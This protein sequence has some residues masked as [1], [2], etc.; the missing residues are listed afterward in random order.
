M[1][2][3]LL[4]LSTATNPQLKEVN[5]EFF[6]YLAANGFEIHNRHRSGAEVAWKGRSVYV[7]VGG[8]SDNAISYVAGKTYQLPTYLNPRE[9]VRW[10]KPSNREDSTYAES[11]LDGMAIFGAQRTVKSIGPDLAASLVS[12]F[13]TADEFESKLLPKGHRI[14]RNGSPGKLIA[15]PDQLIDGFYLVDLAI[16]ANAWD[17]AYTGGGYGGSGLTWGFPITVGGRHFTMRERH[18]EQGRQ[19]T[20]FTIYHKFTAPAER[21]V[22]KWCETMNASLKHGKLRQERDREVY[23]ETRV[24]FNQPKTIA[25]LKKEIEVFTSEANRF[26]HGLPPSGTQPPR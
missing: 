13:T 25:S 8:R 23:L 22:D 2:A 9:L 24:E 1:L 12:I 18:H 15:T 26:L 14:S 4:L 19:Y 7:S 17:W 5:K 11:Y 20:T 3:S 16:L 10:S 6:E 21:N